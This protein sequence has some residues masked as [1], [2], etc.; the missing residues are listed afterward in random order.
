MH[1]P[2]VWTLVECIVEC[3]QGKIFLSFCLQVSFCRFIE[4][5]GYVMWQISVGGCFHFVMML[6]GVSWR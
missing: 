1:L 2:I 6:F 3:L 4:G 5:M